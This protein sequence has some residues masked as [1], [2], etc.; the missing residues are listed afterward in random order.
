M[1]N[2]YTNMLQICRCGLQK[3]SMMNLDRPLST[4][5]ASDHSHQV[6]WYKCAKIFDIILFTLKPF[7]IFPYLWAFV[8]LLP[9]CLLIYNL[10]F[11]V[12]KVKNRSFIHRVYYL[13]ILYTYCYTH[14]IF[15]SV[16]SVSPVLYG[17]PVHFKH[18]QFVFWSSNETL[19]LLS[20]SVKWVVLV[21][22]C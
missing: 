20:P 16:L 21:F 9:H 3:P 6:I 22:F 18:I 15:F 7:V 4:E 13:F 10:T 17:P 5:S 12:N 14:I 8:I 19:C 11:E 2:Y 1:I